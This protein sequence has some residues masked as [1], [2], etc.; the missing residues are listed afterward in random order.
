MP[1][2]FQPQLTTEKREDIRSQSGCPARRSLTVSRA[3]LPAQEHWPARA[4]RMLQGPGPASAR[5]RAR[6]AGERFSTALAV[7]AEETD[8]DGRLRV[9]LIFQDARHAE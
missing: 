9:N 7:H 4:V 6:P 8:E 2:T 3:R 1:S 5:T